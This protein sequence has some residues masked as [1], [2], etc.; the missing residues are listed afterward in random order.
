VLAFAPRGIVGEAAESDEWLIDQAVAEYEAYCAGELRPSVKTRGFPNGELQFCGRL[1]DRSRWTIS[2][3]HTAERAVVPLAVGDFGHVFGVLS[4]LDQADAR[5]EDPRLFPPPSARAGGVRYRFLPV[6]GCSLVGVVQLGKAAVLLAAL[7]ERIAVVYVEGGSRVVLD[8]KSP[9]GLG[10][11][12]V[13]RMLG[14]HRP[15][16]AS[17]KVRRG[18]GLVE[19]PAEVP[20]EPS[21]AIQAHHIRIVRGSPVDVGSGPSISEV[22]RGCFED[23]ARRVEALKQPGRKLK[24]KTKLRTVLGVLLRLGLNSCPNLVG[25]SGELL[26]ELKERAPGVEITVEAF[27][28]VLNLLRKAKT[29]LVQRDERERTWRINLAGLAD[30]RSAL[31]VRLCK[32][33]AGRLRIHDA[34]ANQ[35]PGLGGS[36]PTRGPGPRERP[37][38]ESREAPS[39]WLR[40]FLGGQGRS[41]AEQTTGK[42]DG[43]DGSARGD[44]ADATASRV[45]AVDGVLG[46][47]SCGTAPPVSKDSEL[48]PSTD[49]AGCPVADSSAVEEAAAAILGQPSEASLVMLLAAMFAVAQVRR[50][51]E[52]ARMAELAAWEAER[53][54]LAEQLGAAAQERAELV[55]LLHQLAGLTVGPATR[56]VPTE[57]GAAAADELCEGA[58]AHAVLEMGPEARCPGPSRLGEISPNR[59]AAV[60]TPATPT[61]TNHVVQTEPLSAHRRVDEQATPEHGGVVEQARADAR[62]DLGVDPAPSATTGAPPASSW[63][64]FVID[65]PAKVADPFIA[66]ASP[67][68]LAR[69]RGSGPRG[70]PRGRAVR[71]QPLEVIGTGA[72]RGRCGASGLGHQAAGTRT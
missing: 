23:I 19:T 56:H 60:E 48:V 72:P 38:A 1:E 58:A 40:D 57:H 47:A 6:Q 22:L 5:F 44:A 61:A 67:T 39:S 27:A 33:T 68:T 14:F 34:A 71:A 28:D 41:A 70:P 30:P 8:V 35:R 21:P 54:A 65:A 46:G 66:P 12:D 45:G 25:R 17:A 2:Y 24:G 7:G 59:V 18:G 9:L 15:R 3:V 51:G 50:E 49:S 26:A 10:E 69:P 13:D 31:H 42:S 64:C 4:R 63:S 29:C 62:P 36:E 11:V 52:E 55:V 32:E 43:A 20:V 16:S 37:D 53:R